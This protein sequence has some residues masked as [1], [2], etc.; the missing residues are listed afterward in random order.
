[1]FHKRSTNIVIHC[2]TGSGEFLKVTQRKC[3]FFFIRRKFSEDTVSSGNVFSNAE[4]KILKDKQVPKTV[5]VRQRYMYICTILSQSYQLNAWEG[6]M[7]I[8]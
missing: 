8:Y 2:Q 1:M 5:E 7:K 4:K 3:F 6:R